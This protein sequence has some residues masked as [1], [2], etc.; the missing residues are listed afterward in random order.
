MYFNREERFKF[1]LIKP[2]LEEH[3]VHVLLHNRNT[4][5]MCYRHDNC[6]LKK[7]VF[8]LES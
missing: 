3:N 6:Y 1:T 7:L 5:V 2:Y 4:L 8:V